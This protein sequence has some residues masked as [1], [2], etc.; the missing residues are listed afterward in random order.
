M[1]ESSNDWTQAERMS[2]ACAIAEEVLGKI[3]STNVALIPAGAVVDY[4]TRIQF[5]LGQSHGFLQANR[6]AIL[7]GHNPMF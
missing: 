3:E 2:V 1:I 4:M 6:E 5:V 7:R